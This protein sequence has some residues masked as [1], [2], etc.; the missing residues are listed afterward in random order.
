MSILSAS[1]VDNLVH[2]LRGI[3]KFTARATACA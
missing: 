3:V 2:K 1:I